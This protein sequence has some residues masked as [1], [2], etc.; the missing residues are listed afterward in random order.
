MAR[1]SINTEQLTLAQSLS[2]TLTSKTGT[3]DALKEV[4]DAKIRRKEIVAVG[5]VPRPVVDI[6]QRSSKTL[7]RR[8]RS[9]SR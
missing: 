7:N 9:D 8:Q 4:I 3:T 1:G 2:A 5:E 6:M